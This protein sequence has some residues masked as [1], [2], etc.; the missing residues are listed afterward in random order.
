MANYEMK[1]A[2]LVGNDINS[3]EQVAIPVEISE[4]GNTFTLKSTTMNFYDVD[5]NNK[6]VTDENGNIITYEVPFYPNVLY[7]G[8]TGLTFYNNH[9]I[10][11]V[12]L[13]RGWNGSATPTPS[14][15]SVK[16]VSGPQVKTKNQVAPSTFKKAYGITALVPKPVKVENNVAKQSTPEEINKRIAE[17]FNKRQPAIRK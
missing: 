2:Y 6:P 13:T 4:D 3:V 12:V 16:G 1:Y 11:E 14:K 8:T 15:A 10:S 17:L 7:E 9:I 5:E